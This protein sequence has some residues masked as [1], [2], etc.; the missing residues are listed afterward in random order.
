MATFAG[1]ASQKFYKKDPID[2]T[3]GVTRL[4]FAD[5]LLLVR[6]SDRQVFKDEYFFEN[7]F[8]VYDSHRVDNEVHQETKCLLAEVLYTFVQFFN[9]REQFLNVLYQRLPEFQPSELFMQI[10]SQDSKTR[11]NKYKHLDNVEND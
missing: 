7:K 10:C 11:R 5:F 9:E 1:Q 2:G 8:P 4:S 3:D 6:P